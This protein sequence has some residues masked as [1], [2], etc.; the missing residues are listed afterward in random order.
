[1]IEKVANAI[2]AAAILV[3][4]LGM[5]AV[6]VGVDGSIVSHFVEVAV[7]LIVYLGALGI[8]CVVLYGMVNDLANL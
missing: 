4:G 7:E 6:A 8:I 5:I 2:G 1:M 3:A